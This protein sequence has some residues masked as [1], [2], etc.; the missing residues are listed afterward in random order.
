MKPIPHD[1][2][3]CGL[4]DGPN[5]PCPGCQAEYQ[6]RGASDK[7]YRE[8]SKNFSPP[9]HE[10]TGI[11]NDNCKESPSHADHAN[12]S[13][14]PTIP[15][16]TEEHLVNDSAVQAL[17]ADATVF[18]RGGSLVRTI[19]DDSPATKGIRRSMTP[20]I[21]VLPPALLRERLAANAE[22]VKLRE[23][24][25]GTVQ[26]PEHP[27]GWCVSAV[28]ARGSWPGVRHLEAVVDYPILRP[29]GT[30]LSRPG[31]DPDTGLLLHLVEQQLLIPG[32]PNKD[33]AVEGR[34]E[35][36]E[37][38]CDFPFEGD[39]HRAA[40]LAG[41]L[42]PLARFAFSGPAPL[43]LVDANVRAA[44]KGLLLHTIAK[45]VTGEQF[46]IATYTDDQEELRKR[47]T[48]LAMGGDR[49]VLLDNVVGNFGNAVLD[50]ALTGTSWKDRI[51]G[52]NRIYEG[53]LYVSWYATGNNVAIGGDTSRRICPIRLESPEA[54]PEERQ[55]FRHPNLLAWVGENRSRLLA[56]A[57]TILRAFF[58]AGRPDQNLPAWGSYEGWSAL[59]RS[60]VVWVGMPDPRRACVS[61]Q[62]QADV[63]A[64]H[65]ETLLDCWQQMD[66]DRHGLT[67]AQVIDAIYPK[68]SHSQSQSSVPAYHSDM[69]AALDTIL[70]KPDSRS[71]GNTLRTYKRR[72]F[73]QRYLDQA[74]KHKRAVR[75]AVF[76]ASEFHRGQDETHH[77]H[78]THP[79]PGAEGESGESGESFSPEAEQDVWNVTDDISGDPS[80]DE[81]EWRAGDGPYGAGY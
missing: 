51:L 67:A 31:Y 39:E 71:L 1:P 20:R 70:A 42:T 73:G 74:G 34:D 3:W 14:R 68:L 46:T 60:A 54:R 69:K 53:P 5:S 44:G 38:V 63:A 18:Q 25:A 40:W 62:D 23:T 49:L 8:P 80:S 17:T 45:I 78:Q 64:L 35:L 58:V 16:T 37:V 32:N 75:W 22:W 29:D 66:P 4:A 12:T 61:L 2:E 26:K 33:D 30:I 43:F 47:I 41:L 48:S 7:A 10:T 9:S 77:T 76:P 36:L 52:G 81:E 27:P 21:E 65:M 13:D 57:L 11:G 59:V 28:H 6:A 24:D 56:A 72:I 15:I 19:G 55:K 50:A 79:S